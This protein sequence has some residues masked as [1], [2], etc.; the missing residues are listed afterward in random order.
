MDKKQNFLVSFCI[1]LI[2]ITVIISCIE[3]KQLQLKVNNLEHIET[4]K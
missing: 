4:N 3:I 1:L 2:G